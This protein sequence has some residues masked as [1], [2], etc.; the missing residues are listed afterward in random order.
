M[1]IYVG[2]LPHSMTEEALRSLFE[3]VG[4]VASVRIIKDRMSGQSRGFGFVVMPEIEQA[5]QAITSMNGREVNGRNL[6]VN[7][8]REPERAKGGSQFGSSG[9]R[10]FNNNNRGPR[11]DY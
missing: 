5:Q 11:R 1:N 3:E 6:R 9:P 2:N 8:A 10:R 4:T 7:E